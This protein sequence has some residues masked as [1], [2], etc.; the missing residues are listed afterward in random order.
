MCKAKQVNWRAVNPEGDLKQLGWPW[1]EPIRV[2]V[3]GVEYGGTF[4]IHASGPERGD[5]TEGMNQSTEGLS[6]LPLKPALLLL[7]RRP[8]FFLFSCLI[9]KSDA[10]QYKITRKHSKVLRSKEIPTVSLPRH[11]QHFHFATLP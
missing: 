6:S 4:E 10:S 5:L 2:L 8:L 7:R 11:N 1:M 9:I 3:L